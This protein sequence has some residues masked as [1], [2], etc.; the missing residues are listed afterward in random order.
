VGFNGADTGFGHSLAEMT[1][2]TPRQASAG[3]RMIRKY[4]RQL[5][6]DIIETLGFETPERSK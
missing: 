6:D 1:S 5:P 3:K 4:H 2:L